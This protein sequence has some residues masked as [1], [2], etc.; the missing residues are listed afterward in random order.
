MGK[1]CMCVSKIEKHKKKLKPVCVHMPVKNDSSSSSSSCSAS[2]SFSES[3]CEFDLKLNGEIEQSLYSFMYDVGVLFRNSRSSEEQISCLLDNVMDHFANDFSTYELVTGG[4]F[5]LIVKGKE[6]VRETFLFDVL[7]IV[8]GYALHRL[9][10]VS[11]VWCDSPPGDKRKFA[12]MRA[13][14]NTLEHIREPFTKEILNISSFGDC[15]FIWVKEKGRWLIWKMY[16]AFDRIVNLTPNLLWGRNYSGPVFS[17]I[18]PVVPYPPALVW[19]S[20]ERFCFPPGE[21][22]TPSCQ[23]TPD[24]IMPPI[25]GQGHASS[26]AQ[27]LDQAQAKVKAQTQTK[28]HNKT[29][30]REHSKAQTQTESHN[31]THPREHSKA[32]T[33]MESHNKTQTREH[34]KAQTQT[35]SHN[36]TQTREH[37]KAQTQTESHNKT[38]PREH[39]NDKTQTESH[40]KTQTREHSKDKTKKQDRARVVSGKE[41]ARERAARLFALVKK[42]T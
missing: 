21:K 4:F 11:S 23:V 36:K 18:E 26:K 42:S 22:D 34:S 3:S 14:I 1:K 13:Y 7:E 12:R 20:V 10:N 16:M 38:H 31:K 37:S 29:Q 28:S 25:E 27:A 30:T 15:D 32:Q 9:T 2:S 5:P 6:G 41:A 24:P 33:Q 39:S 35:E 19:P 40:D 17:P 8:I